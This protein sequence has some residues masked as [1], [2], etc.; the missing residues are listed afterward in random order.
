MAR[1]SFVMATVLS[2][3]AVKWPGKY[4]SAWQMLRISAVVYGCVVDI[5]YT[6]ASAYAGA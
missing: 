1:K 3:A 4:M 5:L 2:T 6:H